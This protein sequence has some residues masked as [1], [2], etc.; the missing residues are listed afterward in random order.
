MAQACQTAGAEAHI[1]AWDVRDRE[2]TDHGVA[3]LMNAAGLGAGDAGHKLRAL[4]NN[5]GLAVAGPFDEGLDDDWARC[6]TRTSRAPLL[7]RAC[8]L[9]VCRL[10]MV[11]MGS[12]AGKQVYTGGN[13]YCASKHAVD[14][15]SQAMRIDL[16]DRGIGVSQI[17]PGAAETSSAWCGS[18]EM[19][20]LQG[21]VP[22][23][24]PLVART[25]PGRRIRALATWPRVHQ[26]HGDHAHGPSECPPLEQTTF[27]RFKLGCV[28]ALCWASASGCAVTWRT[29]LCATRTLSPW[30]AADHAQPWL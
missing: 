20:K 7:A 19:R 4:V 18:R 30:M 22:R 14:A 27:M 21:G 16:V 26:R 5:A 24:H 25:S 10:R 9:Y 28:M 3:E 13:V 17:C 1:A 12:I 23:A 8:T 11:N 29:W 15:L 6:W 2:A